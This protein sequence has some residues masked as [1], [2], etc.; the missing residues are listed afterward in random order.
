MSGHVFK[1]GNAMMIEE[2]NPDSKFT[3]FNELLPEIRYMIWKAA[4]RGRLVKIALE[5]PLFDLKDHGPY[6]RML[7][8]QR[9][10][11]VFHN[12]APYPPTMFVNRESRSTTLRHYTKPCPPGPG[13]PT[14]FH[15]ALDSVVLEFSTDI[16][17]QFS[18]TFQT[19]IKMK[20]DCPALMQN[21]RTLFLPCLDQFRTYV[22]NQF[23]E[24]TQEFLKH[25]DLFSFRNLEELFIVG[26]REK[27]AD[28]Q[29]HTRVMIKEVKVLL[30][31]G[32]RRRNLTDKTHKIPKIIIYH[33]TVDL[34]PVF[35]DELKASCS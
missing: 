22:E 2:Q 31:E 9:N 24:I 20:W 33:G 17:S 1:H 18:I 19:G 10:E 8:F 27:T 15:S 23:H 32:F 12:S 11:I 13:I 4:F 5:Y 30:K 14:L 34:L 21:L 25:Y 7:F 3:I 29:G 26:N 35:Q 16:E 28:V 6:M